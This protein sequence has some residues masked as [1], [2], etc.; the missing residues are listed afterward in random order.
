MADIVEFWI[1][2]K[3]VHLLPQPVEG[4]NNGSCTIIHI[5]K[6]DPK[7]DQLREI[8]HWLREEHDDYLFLN[9]NI[10]R[11]YT[12]AEWANAQLYYWNCE[13]AF[14]PLGEQCGTIYDETQAC[15]ICG[16][17]APMVGPLRLRTKTIPRKHDV[18]ATYAKEYIFSARFKAA[19]EAYQLQGIRFQ[20]VHNHQN[21]PI[22][23]FQIQPIAQPLTITGSTI[24]G[25]NPFD[26]SEKSENEVYK[27][28]KGGNH[29]IGL[30]RISELYVH[31]TSD[32]E[33]YD[34]FETEQKIG[35]RRGMLRPAPER[36]CSPAFR[37][38][39]LREKLKGF[40]FEIAHVE[41]SV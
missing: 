28:P 25:G 5:P 3:H 24:T 2:N 30:N 35:C 10:S 34:L 36:L 26:L 1:R 18:S 41:S 37:N 17:N 20:Q 12:K 23:W 19:C 22:D 8:Y 6:D 27:C 32:I 15:D 14:E 13:K 11:H 31:K 21:Q 4:R 39:V 7:I 29:T 40:F 33:Q 9:W 38:M 16:V